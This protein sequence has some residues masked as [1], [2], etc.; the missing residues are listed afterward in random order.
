MGVPTVGGETNF[1]KGYNGN[2]L[3][4]AF[5][6]GIC[7]QDRIFR[8]KAAGQGNPILYSYNFV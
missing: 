4:N 1:D 8:A 3:V 2:I 7:P 6:L 5:T